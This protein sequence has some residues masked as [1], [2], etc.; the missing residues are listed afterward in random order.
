MAHSTVP[1]LY[2]IESFELKDREREMLNVLLK[3]T[4]HRNL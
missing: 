1:V 2:I 3:K 4:D